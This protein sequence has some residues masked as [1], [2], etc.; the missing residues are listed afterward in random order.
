MKELFEYYLSK[1][2]PLAD[3]IMMELFLSSL[4]TC[5]CMWYSLLYV[6]C[7]G[8]QGSGKVDITGEIDPNYGKVRNKLKEFRNAA[9]PCRHDLSPRSLWQC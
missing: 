9:F 1:E 6:T 2:D 8:L 4:G 3:F 5:M 7:E